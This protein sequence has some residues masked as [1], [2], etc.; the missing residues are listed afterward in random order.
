MRGSRQ[1][2]TEIN[3]ALL[4]VQRDIYIDPFIGLSIKI[5]KRQLVWRKEEK[6]KEGKQKDYSTND[7][8]TVSLSAL[9]AF[10]PG[11]DNMLYQV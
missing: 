4:E 5:D 3:V 8:H 6:R 7:K 10:I 2:S 9:A 11:E 1:S